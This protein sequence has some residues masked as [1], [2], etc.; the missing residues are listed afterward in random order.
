MSMAGN[1]TLL[2]TDL[3]CPDAAVQVLSTAP[4]TSPLPAAKAATDSRQHSSAVML[5]MS[6]IRFAVFILRPPYIVI[7]CIPR[8][9]SANFSA[10]QSGIHS[11]RIMPTNSERFH[12]VVSPSPKQVQSTERPRA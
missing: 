9:S 8:R 2:T 11:S 7:S 6:M 12:L 10:A 1:T 5:S 3:I 4:A